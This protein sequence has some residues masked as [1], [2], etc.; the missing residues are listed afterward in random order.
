MKDTKIGIMWI[1]DHISHSQEK[2]KKN[3]EKII[4]MRE[5]FDE[6]DEWAKDSLGNL[7]DFL[8]NDEGMDSDVHYDEPEQNKKLQKIRKILLS[9]PPKS[10]LHICNLIKEK[11]EK[12]HQLTETLSTQ[13]TE[14]DEEPLEE[15]EHTFAIWSEWYSEKK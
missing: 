10:Y 13:N 3:K 7:L 15:N 8:L 9:L 5:I 6:L 4:T 12:Q 1:V 2:K 11:I 14:Y